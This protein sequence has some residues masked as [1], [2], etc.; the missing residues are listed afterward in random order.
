V[1]PQAGGPGEHEEGDGRQGI[2]DYF[3]GSDNGIVEKEAAYHINANEE[4]YDEYPNGSD[5]I[6]PVD[7]LAHEIVN[8]SQHLA[9]PLPKDRSRVANIKG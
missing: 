1:L 9:H 7:Q 4:H 2:L 3:G 8:F 5:E 6:D